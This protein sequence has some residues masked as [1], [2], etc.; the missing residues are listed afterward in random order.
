MSARSLV[1]TRIGGLWRVYGLGRVAVGRTLDEACRAFE[2][3]GL[4]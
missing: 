3:C 2:R 4:N 1:F